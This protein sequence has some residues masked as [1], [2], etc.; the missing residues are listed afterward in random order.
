M[1]AD[2]MTEQVELFYKASG[3]GLDI[4]TNIA[5]NTTK[6]GQVQLGSLFDSSRAINCIMRG[7]LK[8]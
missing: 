3:V 4:D 8:A 5:L 7:I 1:V 2:S 6:I